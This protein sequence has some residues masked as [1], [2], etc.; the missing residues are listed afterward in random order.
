[1]K[2]VLTLCLFAF[3]LILVACQE[4]FEEEKNYLDITIDLKERTATSINNVDVSLSEEET[5]FALIADVSSLEKFTLRVNESIVDEAE[6]VIEDGRLTYR[7]FSTRYVNQNELLPVTYSFDRNGGVYP[8]SVLETLTPFYEIEFKAFNNQNSNDFTVFTPKETGLRWNYKMFIKYDEV[9]DLYQIV[10]TDYKSFGL[11]H[12]EFDDYDFI[13]GTYHQNE[14]PENDLLLGS[15][16]K[17]ESIGTYVYFDGDITTYSGGS[18]NAFFFKPTAVE[19]QLEMFVDTDTSLPEIVK[20][21]FTF[22]G[23]FDGS[24]YL[25]SLSLVKAGEHKNVINLSAHF[26]G[27]SIESLNQYLNSIIPTYTDK[28][29]YL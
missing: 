14:L 10:Y 9:L 11:E 17:S 1:M 4:I 16:F 3:F 2:K 13:L 12:I 20:P 15:L 29:I 8:R 18:I 19:Y 7:F 21:N 25:D 24:T 28:N 5:K 6:Y 27:A 26:E 23:W 22:K